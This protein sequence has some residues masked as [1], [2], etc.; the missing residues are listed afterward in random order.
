MG[1]C[2]GRAA[3]RCSGEALGAWALAQRP[4]FRQKV[5][6]LAAIA[7]KVAKLHGAGL[8]HR[9]LRPDCVLWVPELQRWALAGLRCSAT[10]GQEAPLNFLLRCA[11]PATVHAARQV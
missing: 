11:P 1:L 9:A 5:E 4:T 2:R 3:A 10:I 8:A 7:D 6:A